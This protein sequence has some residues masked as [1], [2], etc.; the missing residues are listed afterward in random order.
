M[1]VPG[2]VRR[3]KIKILSLGQCLNYGYDGVPRS[4]TF[5]NVAA[6]MLKIRFPEIAF[7]FE[8]KFLYHPTGLQAL[9]A[10][11]MMLSKPDVV[12]ISVPAAYAARPWR[13]NRV[14][15]IAPE[16]IDTARSFLQKISAKIKNMPALPQHTLLDNM[17]TTHAPL[18]LDE[19]EKKIEGAV[20]Y[21]LENSC[22]VV[23]MGPGGFNE[24]THE[25]YPIHSPALWA[26]VNHMVIRIG[27]RFNIPI[28]DAQQAL[29]ECDGEVYI[30]NN[31]R[32]SIFGHEIV[33]KEVE[34]VLASEI[35]I[36]HKARHLTIA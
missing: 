26:A 24:D 8:S 22:R 25:D 29:H 30:P 13:V 28:V 23:L 6:L 36:V 11:R 7:Q 31:H 10:H 32:W 21:C 18:K 14:Y 20:K 16:V 27:Q 35:T 4:A 9:L 5:N 19:Y 1:N 34:E 17:L 15:E 12:M 3:K 2:N 33:A